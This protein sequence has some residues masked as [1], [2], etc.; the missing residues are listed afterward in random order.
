MKYDID[1]ISRLTQNEL[2]A[3]ACRWALSDDTV[4]P[5]VEAILREALNDDSAEHPAAA[6]VAD[7]GDLPGQIP[8]D[9][10]EL[11]ANPFEGVAAQSLKAKFAKIHERIMVAVN[12][13]YEGGARCDRYSWLWS[14]DTYFNVIKEGGCPDILWRPRPDLVRGDT[15]A[16]EERRAELEER[17]GNIAAEKLEESAKHLRFTGATY[18]GEE[19]PIVSLVNSFRVAVCGLLTVLPTAINPL[20]DDLS[21]A[22]REVDVIIAAGR[23][24]YYLER[25]EGHR[26]I[27][28]LVGPVKH[29]VVRGFLAIK[30]SERIA[31]SKFFRDEEK[32]ADAEH[33]ELLNK[34]WT[35]RL[36]NGDEEKAL[37]EAIEQAKKE[38]AFAKTFDAE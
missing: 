29:F 7:E 22:A 9:V 6:T 27:S 2:E 13:Q 16:D 8:A 20:D 32:R 23:L 24:T 17:K 31:Y 38:L 18:G 15:K 33:T 3:V 28:P 10:A 30:T 12:A 14:H 35:E 19:L 37:F 4:T 5:E 1:T 34:I 11:Y 25:N 36:R 26:I 21:K